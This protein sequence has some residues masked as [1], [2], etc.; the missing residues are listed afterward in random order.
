M[1]D[2]DF[3]PLESEC[4]ICFGHAID[5]GDVHQDGIVPCKSCSGTGYKPTEFGRAV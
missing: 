5:Q 2:T 3:P 4:E 1:S